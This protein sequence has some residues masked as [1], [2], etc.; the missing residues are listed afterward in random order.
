MKI[1]LRENV[2]KLGKRGD[3]IAVKDG[4]ARNY[5]IPKGLGLPASAENLRRIETEKRKYIQRMAQFKEEREELAEKLKSIKLEIP[6][7]VSDKGHLYGSIQEKNILEAL[8]KE[9]VVLEPDSVYLE[10][11]I[12]EIGIYKFTVHVHPAIED[13]EMELWVTNE[14]KSREAETENQ[15][16]TED[17]A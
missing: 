14:D 4:Y 1:V 12:K 13:V 16:E 7:K 2:P 9:G 8:E 17:E 15:L 5:L 6:S 3:V 11:P 10:E